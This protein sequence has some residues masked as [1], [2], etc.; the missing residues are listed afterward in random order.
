M[1]LATP[2]S[3]PMFFRETLAEIKDQ[4]RAEP[5]NENL[6]SRIR[7]QSALLNKALVAEDRPESIVQECVQLAALACRLAAEGDPAFPK[8]RWP[9]E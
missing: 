2:A 8:Y 9:Y 7:K 3:S 1:P 6:A 4:R 5:T